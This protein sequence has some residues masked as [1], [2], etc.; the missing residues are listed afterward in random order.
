MRA[1][2]WGW[3]RL[4]TLDV[5]ASEF[6]RLFR[7][8]DRDGGSIGHDRPPF[9][10]DPVLARLRASDVSGLE[11]LFG[12]RRTADGSSRAQRFADVA[13]GLQGAPRRPSSLSRGGW[14]VPPERRDL[15]YAGG[16]ALNCVANARL[17]R[18]GPFRSLFILGAAHDA[19]T[20][21]GAALHFAYQ[22]DASSAR[23]APRPAS[24]WTHTVPR[25]FV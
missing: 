20:A 11:S 15:V 10:I 5:F 7:I 19:G 22:K 25:P 16:V 3:P 1:K 17:E 4:E 12:P 9:Q 23:K 24:R 14:R 8:A 13:A 6:D 21:V 18:E 2:S